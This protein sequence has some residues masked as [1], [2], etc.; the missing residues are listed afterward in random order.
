MAKTK[1]A[2]I[3]TLSIPRL[4]LC[5]AALLAK[6]LTTVRQALQIPI[7]HVHAW[8]DSSI[9]IVW[10]D[11]SPKHYKT[12]VGNRIASITSLI[13]PTAWR[14]VPTDQNPADCASQ[15]LSSAELRH[16]AMWWKGP[17]WLALDPVK[18]PIQPS[19]TELLPL[20]NL[21]TKPVPCNP[22]IASPTY[23]LESLYSSYLKLVH[24]TAWL[25]RAAH[26]LL[27]KSQAHTKLLDSNLTTA[28]VQA[29]ETFLFARSQ[30]FRHVHLKLS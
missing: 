16:H 18:I 12:F 2:P 24:V 1:V 15:G 19:T 10:L 8:S 22:G 17:P 28:E 13:P 11:G 5:G 30:L 7:E 27:A 21:E 29:A 26:N 4:E 14:H 3:K 9:V 23:W 20:G 6:L 25:L